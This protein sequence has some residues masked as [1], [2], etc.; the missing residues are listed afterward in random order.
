MK[1]RLVYID[2]LRGFLII[3][4]VLGHCI[5]FLDPDFDHNIVFRYI[6]SFHMPLFMFIS[7]FV[8]YK[9][10]Y[11]WIS[12]KHRFL[13]LVISFIAWAMIG[14]VIT[15][16]YNWYWLTNPDTALWFLWV[17]FWIGTLH[18]ALSKLSKKLGIA[19]EVVFLSACIVFLGI[20]FISKL[21]FGFHLLA[22]YLPFYCLGSIARKYESIL[23]LRLQDWCLIFGLLFVT[24]GFF[25]MRNESPT[26]LQSDSQALIFGYKFLVG[27]LGCIFFLSI[28]RVFERNMLLLN[29]L[30]GVTLGIYAIHQLVIRCIVNMD[31]ITDIPLLSANLWAQIIGIFILAFLITL[32]VYWLL[33]SFNVTSKLFLGK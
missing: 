13:Q 3:L 14:M 15:N 20:L 4:V 10:K 19:E 30:G 25:W 11:K 16:D 17:L 18:M 21:S 31:S 8:S 26:F 12:I 24:S 27:F 2:N 7:G 23:I 9:S 22:W 5:Q 29:K 33:N 32:F 1:Q 28:I 6:Y